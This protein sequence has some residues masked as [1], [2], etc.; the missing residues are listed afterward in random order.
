ML[1]KNLNFFTSFKNKLPLMVV[2][3]VALLVAFQNIDL[4]TYYSGWDNIHAEFNIARYVRQVFFGAWLEHQG[5]GAPAA[6]GHLAEIPR[7][8]ILLLLKLI[9]P[10]NLIRIV[11][12]FALYLIG[13]VGMYFYLVK[14]WLNT[15]IKLST[16]I[17]SVGGI[18]YLLHL[19]TLQQFYISFEMFIVQFAFFP[20]LLMMIHQLSLEFNNKNILKFIG[21]Q[22]LI[23]PSAHTSTVFYL[24][25]LFSMLYAFFIEFQADLASIKK[26]VKFSFLIGIL[27]FISNAYWIIPNLYYSFNNSSYVA[28]S[29]TNQNFAPESVWSIKEAGTLVN[30]LGGTHYLFNW[31]DY[32]FATQEFEYIFNEWQSH[33]ASIASRIIMIGTGIATVLGFL[34]TILN[35]KLG[36]KKRAIIIFYLVSISLIW[37]ELLPSKYL[38]DLFYQSKT[39]TE[40]FRN[41][42]TKLSILYSFVIVLLFVQFLQ[43]AIILLNKIKS[44]KIAQVLQTALLF[45]FAGSIIYLAWPSFQG[46]FISDKLQVQYPQQ[47]TAMFDY[48]QSKDSDLRIL[49]L[50][51]FSHAA[52]VYQDW[53]FIEPQ[54]GYQGMGFTFFGASQP[55]LERDFDRWQETNDFFYH[56]LS[57]ALNSQDGTQFLKIVNKY[58]IDL[59]IIDETKIDPYRDYDYQRDHSLVIS[60]GFEPVWQQDFLTVYERNQNNHQAEEQLFVPELLK[61]VSAELDRVQKD[62]VYYHEANYLL[63]DQAQAYVTYPF[64]DLLTNQPEN[65]KIDQDQTTVVKSIFSNDY[66]LTLPGLKVQQYLTPVE[67]SYLGNQVNIKFPDEII[68]T[69]VQEIYLPKLEDISFVVDNP[70]KQI[71]VFFNQQGIVVAPGQ[72]VY[73]TIAAIVDQPIK[74]AYADKPEQFLFTEQGKV[75]TPEQQLVANITPNWLDFKNDLVIELEA[76]NQ[77]EI[78]TQFPS[79]SVDFNQNPVTNCSLPLQGNVSGTVHLNNT[80]YLADDYG[81][82]CNGLNSFE[83]L[84]SSAS[85]YLLHIKGV[86]EQGRSIKFFVNYANPVLNGKDFMLSEGEFDTTWSLNQVGVDPRNYYLFN[87]ETRS[88]GKT[89]KNQLRNID[90][91]AFNLEKFAQL[92][93]E[94]KNNPE[95][96]TNNV[97]ILEQHYLLDSIH[98]VKLGCLSESCYLALDQSYDDLWLAVQ[99]GH[100]GLLPHLKLN[101]WA[102]IWQLNQSGWVII[103]YLPELISLLSLSGLSLS[104]LWLV[105]STFRKVS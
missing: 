39:F 105:K 45:I 78:I 60:V 49:P 56:E 7:L 54:N 74:V 103:F 72:K 33:L 31:K 53:S 98:L 29:F 47:Y 77:L 52:W 99:V 79:F 10:D 35:K 81:V 85:S 62:Y 5:L 50:P 25:I 14:H 57:T 97:Q 36:T 23:A 91:A 2:I 88:F 48:L 67:V 27:T 1:K 12:I 6:Q 11:Y 9:L 101:N 17:A 24:A 73:P 96:V 87:W 21:L 13:G 38:V 102:N 46:H 82:A 41:P 32:S 3:V 51:Q 80:T 76:V 20:F 18:F 8:P 75:E 70:E 100:V 83:T 22:L 44:K 89:S 30:F 95:L 34:A 65:I 84:F 90:I 93:L 86:N 40:I 59:V 15:K 43:T 55:M 64:A 104:I 69:N 4:N 71:I 66:V 94:D 61:L 58:N 37:I 26:S 28:D 42:F 92:R 19:L 16:W 68:K 63:V